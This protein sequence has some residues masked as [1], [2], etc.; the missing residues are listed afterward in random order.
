LRQDSFNG[1]PDMT[2]NEFPDRHAEKELRQK[3]ADGS[4][5]PDDY[6]YLTDL[7]FPSGRY[8]EAIALCQ[9]ALTLPLTSFKKAQ[10]SME[11][12]WIYYDIGQQARATPL[13]REALALLSTEPKSAE[14]FYCLGA[15]QA[16]VSHSESFEDP[17]A[18]AEAARLA[19]DWL[20][21]AVAGNSDF[22]DKP[23]AYIDAAR[24]HT[25]LGNLDEA[26]VYCERCL[27]Q[28]INET[29]RISCL[30]VYAQA[31]QREERFAEAEQAI[32]EA[33]RCRKN[34]TSGLFQI[35]I[36][37]GAIQ[38]FTNRL[39]ESRR[40]YEQALAALK[41]DPY[42][43]S[44]A[45][46]LGEI[47]FNLAT[48]CYELKE[49]QDAVSAYSGVLR[50]KSKDIP[51]YWT[52]LYWLGR[53]YEATEDHRGA[54]DCYGE[55]L[56]SPNATEDDKTLARK[57]LTWVVAKLDYE[58]GKYKE[59]AAAFEQLVSHSTM[60]DPDY[61]PAILWLG[62]SH[63]G[64][65]A[66]TKAQMF[67]EEALNSAHTSD[68]N[69]L[70]AQKG[71]TRSLARLAHESGD[72]REAAAKYEEVLGH[73]GETDPNRWNTMIWLGSSYQGLGNYAK[74]QECYQ[75]V[76]AS[77]YAADADKVLARKK[78]TSSLGKVYYESKSYAEAIAAF[79]DVL[80]FCPETEPHRF[81]ALIWLGY[82]YLA[83]KMYGRA[84][85]CFEEVVA[86]SCAS[87]AE[88]ASA[89]QGLALL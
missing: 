88:K 67:Y 12:G 62:S 86:S 6:R 30:I 25:M 49:Y 51:S 40:S 4:Q 20:E 42:F 23:H 45:E 70:I 38:R 10:L 43:H 28:E 52:T 81:H 82:S 56:A 19:L 84:R 41:S 32:A 22:K 68:A 29:Q 2:V 21:K 27:G 61:W 8:D 69:K 36:E 55:V 60:A 26:I 24:L 54:R 5:D 89:R 15:S 73:Y 63:E 74:E 59:A 50:C 47:Y 66:Y 44:D 57:G 65:G 64:L 85:D 33:V 37:L 75:R 9:Q 83:T 14:V 11:L 34:Y 87:E 46:I 80:T 18:G 78:L 72:Y 17:N 79:E 31:L 1:L 3:I 13:A 39:A 48:V 77:R 16:L 76:L 53:S 7:L 58:S 35:Y 71:H